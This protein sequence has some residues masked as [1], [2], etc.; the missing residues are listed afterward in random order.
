MND[1]CPICGSTDIDDY[2]CMD[3]FMSASLVSWEDEEDWSGEE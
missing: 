2:G 3:C 1:L